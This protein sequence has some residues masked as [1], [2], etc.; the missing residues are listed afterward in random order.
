MLFRSSPAK[1][2]AA[3]VRKHAH[4]RHGRSTG[5]THLAPHKL[6]TLL[7]HVGRR[8]ALQVERVAEDLGPAE[9]DARL[10]GRVLVRDRL[11]DLGPIWAA[12]LRV[13]H[14]LVS[15]HR[16]DGSAQ[17]AHV[18]WGAEVSDC[19]AFAAH[20]AMPIIGQQ[21]EATSAAVVRGAYSLLTMLLISSTLI[22]AVR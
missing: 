3:E 21:P 12:V 8:V 13:G 22:L 15:M 16:E 10:G 19:V 11:E 7:P 4:R 1:P 5:T 9:E 14:C 6:S 20:A 17:E 18:G 2:T